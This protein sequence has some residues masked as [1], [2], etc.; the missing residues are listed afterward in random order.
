MMLY[1]GNACLVQEDIHYWRS[2]GVT[3]QNG[4]QLCRHD[5]SGSSEV[6]LLRNL[7]N[8]VLKIIDFAS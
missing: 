2:A 8:T 3:N 5:N 6:D 1:A 7:R 4:A